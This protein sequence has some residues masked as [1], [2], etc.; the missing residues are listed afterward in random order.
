M[1]EVF[2]LATN[3]ISP[4]GMFTEEFQE[5]RER[6][7]SDHYAIQM[8]QEQRT[9]A[10]LQEQGS[11]YLIVM[12]S[13]STLLEQKIKEYEKKANIA[14]TK[15]KNALLEKT[16]IG[17]KTAARQL[18]LK[19][20]NEAQ[21][22]YLTGMIQSIDSLKI[23]IDRCRTTVDFSSLL[24]DV[25][26]H[27]ADEVKSGGLNTED[28]DR[29]SAEFSDMG[30]VMSEVNQI[31]ADLTESTNRVTDMVDD[32][33]VITDEIQAQIDALEMEIKTEASYDQT[34]TVGPDI[35]G[36]NN[37]GSSMD[38]YS[39]T[40]SI[41]SMNPSYPSAM[42]PSNLTS[43]HYPSRKQQTYYSL[44]VHSYPTIPI[45]EPVNDD[46][47]NGDD[48]PSMDGNPIE[49]MDAPFTETGHKYEEKEL[50]LD[51]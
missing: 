43:S 49:V 34:I 7:P 20:M 29:K 19:C 18:R 45:D 46:T 16:D 13:A 50:V 15:A 21:I 36:G 9:Q 2:S 1:G 23:T 10:R 27:V 41:P 33:G 38:V 44:P 35:Y 40:T 4:K 3:C 25:M 28:L 30:E 22:N 14:R 47:G 24:S 37:G 17:K 26:K 8:T 12:D 5:T 51:T 11:K 32:D 39:T 6:I 48:G 42:Y 31:L